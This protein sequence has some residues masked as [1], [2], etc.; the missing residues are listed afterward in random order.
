MLTRDRPE[1][2]SKSGL[3]SFCL[4]TCLVSYQS[5]LCKGWSVAL[6]CDLLKGEPLFGYGMSGDSQSHI[7]YISIL[8]LKQSL[9]AIF[10][11]LTSIVPYL[12]FRVAPYLFV[13]GFTL[14]GFEPYGMLYLWSFDF[15]SYLSGC[16]LCKANLNHNPGRR[17]FLKGGR[18]GHSLYGCSQ[19]R[20]SLVCEGQASSG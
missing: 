15:K 6:R 1:A 4:H 13:P 14:Q 8:G 19:Y 5:K 2:I 17:P 16:I 3:S 12:N 9:L 20:A 7:T 11:V 18:L 10:I